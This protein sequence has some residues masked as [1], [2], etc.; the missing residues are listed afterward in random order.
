M[1]WIYVAA[2]VLVLLFVLAAV[3]MRSRAPRLSGSAQAKIKTQWQA[4]L[5]RTDHHRQIIEADAV[6]A[7]LLGFL[8]FQGSM[9]DKLKKGA[10]YIPDLQGVWT[11]HKFRN[12][13][14]HEPGIQPRPA[15]VQSSLA[16]F[17]RVINK[18][19]P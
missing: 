1:I 6:V 12:R 11:A 16:A 19:C 17:G 8:G 13:L 9:A 7:N 3:W 5:Q 10:K 18:Y 15:D 14:A 4:V 2:G